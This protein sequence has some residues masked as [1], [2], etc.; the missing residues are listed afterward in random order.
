MHSSHALCW[1]SFDSKAGSWSA[2]LGVDPRTPK[3]LPA[4]PWPRTAP[5]TALCLQANGTDPWWSL[6]FSWPFICHP[7]S[8]PVGQHHSS[9]KEGF[10]FQH[11]AA[12][13]ALSSELLLLPVHAELLSKKQT[14]VIKPTPLGTKSFCS[15]FLI[16]LTKPKFPQPPLSLLAAESP[17]EWELSISFQLSS[18]MTGLWVLKDSHPPASYGRAFQ[19]D[20]F[21]NTNL[22]IPSVCCWRKSLLVLTHV[23]HIKQLN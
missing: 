5:S 23:Q 14:A 10:P 18:R 20:V 15:C 19:F 8:T 7:A 12:G 4:C 2:L 21:I 16:F 1:Y 17:S 11:L 6:V 22:F 9:C 13:S 3:A